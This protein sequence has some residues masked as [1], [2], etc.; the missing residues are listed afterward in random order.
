MFRRKK[1]WHYR[2]LHSYIFLLLIWVFTGFALGTIVLLYPLRWWVT[3]VR[4]SELSSGIETVGVVGIML[5]LAIASF[6]LSWFLFKWHRRKRATLVSIT[7]IAVPLLLAISALALFMKPDVVNAGAQSTEIAKQFTIGPY[8]TESRIKQLKKEGYTGIISLLH[9]AVVP[10]EPSLIKEEEL[11]ASQEGIQF[12][13]APMLPWVGDNA[14]SLKRIEE[15]AKTGKGRYYIHC[16]LGKDRVN[17]VKNVIAKV[18]GSNT[19]IQQDIPAT[20]RSFEEGKTFERGVIYK[21]GEQVYM[22]PFPTNEELLGYF[23]AGQVKTVVNL[24]NPA[25]AENIKWIQNERQGLDKSAVIFKNISL[26]DDAKPKRLSEILDSITSFQK[27]IAIH[28]WGT[29]YPSTRNFR[30]AYFLRTGQK[31][32]NLSNGMIENF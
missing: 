25:D 3:Y 10:F 31:P 6:I 24:M 29:H 32:V 20:A 27:P 21:L 23:L 19:S 26:P 7:S 11:A 9:P 4:E 14:A 22:T 12:I 2:L 8:P 16:Y 18:T 5:M 15:I 30:K 13:K 1:P 28:H 17:V